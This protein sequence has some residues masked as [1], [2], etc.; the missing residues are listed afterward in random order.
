LSDT[1]LLIHTGIFL[2]VASLL[3]WAI[4]DPEAVWSL[5]DAT[6]FA[7]LDAALIK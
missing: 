2:T 5:L 3:V 4:A 7:V 6:V 1:S